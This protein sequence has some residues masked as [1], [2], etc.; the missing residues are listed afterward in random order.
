MNIDDEA[1]FVSNG[2]RHEMRKRRRT[3]RESSSSASN[4]DAFELSDRIIS[5]CNKKSKGSEIVTAYGT[6]VKTGAYILPD[7]YEEVMNS[8]ISENASSSS[9]LRRKVAKHIKIAP[10]KQNSSALWAKVL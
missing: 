8:K 1:C 3:E 7:S 2:D 9:E 10:H 6:Y 4:L 5:L